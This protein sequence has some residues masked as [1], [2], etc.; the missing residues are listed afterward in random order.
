MNYVVL[1]LTVGVTIFAFVD[2][3]IRNDDEVRG[4][5]RLVWLMAMLFVP[6]LASTAYLLY[7]RGES[8]ALGP[9]RPRVIAP[10]DDPDFLRQLD[11]RQHRADPGNQAD[12]G[13]RADAEEKR[14]R[15]QHPRHGNTDRE[16][17][18][19]ERPQHDR[20]DLRAPQGESEEQP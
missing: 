13:N 9:G 3:W 4:L 8:S 12:P 11:L 15:E 17:P 2:C 18:P 7:G 5:P 6:L 16:H 10:D 19:R 14:R 1:L 20:P